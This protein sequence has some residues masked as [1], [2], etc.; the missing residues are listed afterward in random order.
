[1]AGDLCLKAFCLECLLICVS[2]YCRSSDQSEKCVIPKEFICVP[3]EC[4]NPTYVCEDPFPVEPGKCPYFNKKLQRMDVTECTAEQACP[5]EP[6][7][8]SALV[9]KSEDCLAN[10]KRTNRCFD[11]NSKS[12]TEMNTRLQSTKQ[13][14]TSSIEH[15]PRDSGG[16]GAAIGVVVVLLILVA[17]LVMLVVFYR[18]NIC[19]VRKTIE[20]LVDNIRNHL[21][22]NRESEIIPS[23]RND[24]EA[25]EAV[26]TEKPLLT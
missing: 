18:R 10:P 8:A 9:Q 16:S 1:M 21:Q 22:T 25:G 7:L 23:D 13:H 24:E 3:D 26:E 5:S 19:G 11:Q 14:Q 15:L 2:A 20:P 12:T 4:G 17:I 6:Y